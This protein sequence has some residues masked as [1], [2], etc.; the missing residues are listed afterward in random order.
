MQTTVFL[1]VG[2][3]SL[4]SYNAFAMSTLMF[5]LFLYQKLYISSVFLLLQ[6]RR[7]LDFV[8]S[9]SFHLIYLLQGEF[10]LVFLT[11]FGVLLK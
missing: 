10:H 11:G 1:L 3:F 6:Q 4:L 9:L 8:D 5:F 7:A 2:L